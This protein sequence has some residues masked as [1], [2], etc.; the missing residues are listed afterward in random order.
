MFILDMS[1]GPNFAVALIKKI[2]LYTAQIYQTDAPLWGALAVIYY[3]G[4]LP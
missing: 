2:S 1:C 4:D 3:N